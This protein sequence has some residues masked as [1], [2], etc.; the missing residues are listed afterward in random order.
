MSGPRP[1]LAAIAPV[2]AIA[3]ALLAVGCGGGNDEPS[4]LAALAPPDSP[5]YVELAFLPDDE[6]SE[7]LASLADRIAGIAEPEA[8]LI[9]F[10]D[11][12]FE[13]Q[14]AELTWA[15]DIEPW[16]GDTAA[17]FV[18]SFE[19]ADA[20]AGMVD[21]A[22]MT[23]VKDAEEAEAFLDTLKKDVQPD[24]EFEERSYEDVDYLFGGADSDTAVG[25]VDG[26]MVSGTEP[27]L[28]AAVDASAGDSLADS[29]DFSEE[30][31]SLDDENLMEL[32]LDLGTALDAAAA[33]AT[34]PAGAEIDAARSALEPLLAQPLAASL[35][36]TEGAITLEASAAGG[37]GIE[38]D[39]ELLSELPADAWV[40]FSL[41]KAGEA[42]RESLS[43]IGSL[44]SELGDESLDPEAIAGLLESQTGLDLEED[45]LAWLGDASFYVS[46]TSRKAFR[47]GGLLETSDA[48]AAASALDAVQELFEERIGANTDEPSVEGAEAG[49]RA[50]GPGGAGVELALRDDQVIAAF[51][52]TDPAGGLIEPDETLGDSD[53]YSR[54]ADALG[55]DFAAAAFIAV[56]DFLVVAEKGDDGDADYDAARP[57]TQHLE[58]LI[59][60]TASEDGRERSRVVLGLAE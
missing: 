15:D 33:G 2:A 11:S 29:E 46:G 40:A 23:T 49:F 18:R 27:A 4:E 25:L 17:V 51:G 14:D 8:E 13:A 53:L 30:A 43:G 55:D 39:S 54:A 31:G 47:A 34:G 57:Y 60:G 32:W 21:A 38:G 9:S 5:L 41:T 19:P 16:L 7:A 42:L 36:A 37:A 50:S 35:A 26:V 10:V 6:R 20:A 3:L 59:L 45:L 58:Y 56:Q 28:K 22:Y 44:G 24:I 1:A 12:E 52:G 48:E